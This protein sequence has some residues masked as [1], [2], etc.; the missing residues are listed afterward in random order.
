MSISILPIFAATSG[1]S[2][3]FYGWQVLTYARY[4]TE[5]WLLQF[6]WQVQI[7]LAIVV[8]SSLT[9]LLLFI[10]F[11]QNIIARDRRD[12]LFHVNS[13]RFED[14]FMEI[15]SSDVKMSREEM[16][17]ICK[18]DGSE[19]HQLN[20]VSLG[21]LIV[22]L[23][24]K[25]GNRVFLPNMQ[26]L[27]N[28]SGV[29]ALL[30]N[31]M[32]KGNHVVQT[33]QIL[34]TLP[35]RISEGA[36]AAYTGHK[37]QRIR[38]LARAY[39]GFCSKTEPFRYVMLDLNESFQLW[40]PTT[41]HRLCG[42]HT[43]KSHPTPQLLE[44]AHRSSNDAKKALFI[45]E[46]PYWGSDEEK[47][48]IREALTSPSAKCRSAAIHALAIIGDPDSEEDL[49]RTYPTQF[50]AAKRET[51][52]AIAKINTGRQTEFLRS[53][54]L[55]STSQ[56]TRAVAL[57]CLYNYGEEGRRVFRELSQT[58]LDDVRVFEQIMSTEQKS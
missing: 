45:S 34:M 50:P 14:A 15:L 56:D 52:R 36:L 43:A 23:R 30:E 9:I 5:A 10:L 39:F 21:R 26:R 32:V 19:L 35:I 2:A 53:A 17:Y 16:E 47:R 38:E 31:N 8:F 3:Y 1:P 44:L 54:Y 49:I 57:A 42:W 4:L 7:S 46:I 22:S 37:N 41:F 58:G 24:L 13:E 55:T 11:F 12:H 18:A 29:Q 48:G 25:L 33:L 6:P 28:M 20:A 51:L 40:Y 27:C